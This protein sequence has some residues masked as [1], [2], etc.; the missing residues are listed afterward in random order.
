MEFRQLEYFRMISKLE[1]FTRAAEFLHVSQP[2][3]TK[4]I[5]NLEAELKVT[6]IDRTQKHVV[7][8]PE[9]KAFLLHATKILQDVEEAVK[10]MGRFQTSQ[11]GVVKLGMPPMIEAYLF[12]DIF[13]YFKEEYPHIEVDVVEYAYSAKVQS[14]IEENVLDLGII[15]GGERQGKNK[16]LLMQDQLCLCVHNEHPLRFADKVDFSQLAKEKFILQPPETMQYKKIC[17]RCKKRGFAPD[18]LLN[19]AQLKTIKHLVANGAGVSFLLN[20]VTKDETSFSIV[21]VE[22]PIWMD[23]CLVWSPNKCLSQA[24]QT[25]VEFI[26]RYIKTAKFRKNIGESLP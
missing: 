16:L 20:L 26:R 4:A 11:Q 1:N 5:K 24:G 23:I 8:T 15:L 14:K 22:P 21:P 2:S 25:F 3:V 9:G 10:D 13:T 6:L 7:L 12:P 18:V 17:A 19:T